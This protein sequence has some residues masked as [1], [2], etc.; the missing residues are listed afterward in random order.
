M[1]ERRRFF[2]EKLTPY[3]APPMWLHCLLYVLTLGAYELFWHYMNWR[4][5][6]LI[7]GDPIWPPL[8]GLFFYFFIPALVG[9]LARSSSLAGRSDPSL[10]PW[11]SALYIAAV[12]TASTLAE[13]LHPLF[14]LS[15]FPFLTYLNWRAR[16]VNQQFITASA[17]SDASVS[18]IVA[19]SPLQS[20]HDVLVFRPSF[21]TVKSFRWLEIFTCIAVICI[22][23]TFALDAGR[24]TIIKA[25]L[26]E[27]FS[28]LGGVRVDMAEKYAFSGVW[29]ER[30]KLYALSE[31][32]A[33]YFQ[34]VELDASGALHFTFSPLAEETPGTI[35]FRSVVSNPDGALRTLGWTCASAHSGP[36]KVYGDDK[37]SL[38]PEQLPYICRG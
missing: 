18:V 32:E 26:T 29:P 22:A 31:V 37:S 13:A 38:P 21:Q 36:R 27:A 34:P 17:Q 20:G 4:K 33:V 16:W 7:S 15:A 14:I 24:Q 35:S 3:F 11:T 19:G 23:L 12:I 25:R 8:R 10:G 2:K 1:P 5:Y 6:R 9:N 30:D 28:L